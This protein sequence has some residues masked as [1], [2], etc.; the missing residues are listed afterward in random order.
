MWGWLEALRARVIDG[1]S[2]PRSPA[3]LQAAVLTVDGQSNAV[4]IIDHSESG[5]MV[6]SEIVLRAGTMVTL[7]LLDREPRRGQVRWSREGRIGISFDGSAQ[8][9]TGYQDES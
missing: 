4:R 2:A 1:R 8:A 5:A 6:Q 7:Q 3:Q 9:P